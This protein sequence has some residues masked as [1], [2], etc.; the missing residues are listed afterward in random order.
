M[1]EQVKAYVEQQNIVLT[2]KKL[3]LAVSGGADSVC[4]FDIFCRLQ[5][6]Q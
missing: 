6:C 5:T 1:V 3:V 2:G 4:L